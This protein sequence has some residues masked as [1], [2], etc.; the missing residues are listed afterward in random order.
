MEINYSKNLL[1][2][3]DLDG[4]LD[5]LEES[6]EGL[7][8]EELKDAEE[9]VFELKELKG[10]KD[11][12]GREWFEGIHLINESNWINY[13]R[14]QEEYLNNSLPSYI[15]IDWKETAKNVATEYSTVE[16]MGETFYYQ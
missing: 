10:V 15:I 16:L 1:N 13:V 14:E 12:L 4:R 2:T 3:D 5:E 6:L 8:A 7:N 11:Q 9:D